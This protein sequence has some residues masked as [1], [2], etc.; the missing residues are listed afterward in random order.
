MQ[1]SIGDFCFSQECDF[2]WCQVGDY[3]RHRNCPT[4]RAVIAG[5]LVC[6]HILFERLLYEDLSALQMCT[7]DNIKHFIQHDGLVAVTLYRGSTVIY[8]LL[9]IS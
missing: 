8:N 6:M 2:G 3:S 9:M 1:L 4:W 7:Y 5:N